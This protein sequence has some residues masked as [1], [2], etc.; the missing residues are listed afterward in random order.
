MSNYG[1]F[2]RYYRL[3]GGQRRLHRLPD[4]KEF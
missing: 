4:F 1:G 2:K 3:A